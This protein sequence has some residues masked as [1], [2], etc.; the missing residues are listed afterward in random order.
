[1]WN[2]CSDSRSGRRGFAPAVILAAGLATAIGV[3]PS[4]AA[5]PEDGCRIDTGR[6]PAID[7]GAILEVVSPTSTTALTAMQ[8]EVERIWTPHGVR[9]RW[10]G[11]GHDAPHSMANVDV[12][13]GVDP[14]EGGHVRPTGRNTLGWF[15]SARDGD[16]RPI[17]TIFP[18][19]AQRLAGALGAHICGHRCLEAWLERLQGTLLGRVLAHEIGHYLLGPE[20]TSVGLMR[21]E[22]HPW[23]VLA[24]DLGAVSLTGSQVQRLSSQCVDR[25]LMDVNATTW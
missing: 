11:H 6:D 9:I 23:A 13:V 10:L 21:A 16:S 4:S 15:R 18:H 22:I 8:A 19:Q 12:L 20:H 25:Q 2:G 17:I 24:S 14:R 1:M 3:P 5:G 7:V